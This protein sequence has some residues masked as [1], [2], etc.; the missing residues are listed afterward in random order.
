MTD[1]NCHP[2]KTYARKACGGCKHWD[3]TKGAHG[4]GLCLKHSRGKDSPDM[5]LSRRDMA[6]CGLYEARGPLPTQGQ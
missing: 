5:Y 3:A 6:P 2:G 4:Y 1:Q